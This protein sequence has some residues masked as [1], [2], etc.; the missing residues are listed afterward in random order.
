MGEQHD[1]TIRASF[2]QQAQ[3]FESDRFIGKLVSEAEW[4]LGDLDLDADSLA[5]DVAAGTGHAARGLAPHVR[6]VVA[7]DATP[8]MLQAGQRAAEAG[9][10]RNI[11]F[12]EADA[13]RMPFLDGSFDIVVCRFAAHHFPSPEQLF[14]EMLRCVRPGGQVVVA[15]LVADEDPVVAA[16]QNALEL[17][18]DPSHTRCLPASELLGQLTSLGAT[19]ARV[20]RRGTVRPLT[21]WLAQTFAAADVAASIDAALRD[22]LGGGPPTGL[23]PELRGDDL[24]F[25]QRFAAVTVRAPA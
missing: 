2:T 14:A 13:C 12:L 17:L 23:H 8:A 4:V 9:S 19:S 24:W 25:E 16:A 6:S 10:I 15:D 18:R 5:L 3:A 22:E 20:E 11:V 1:D 21:P 7:V